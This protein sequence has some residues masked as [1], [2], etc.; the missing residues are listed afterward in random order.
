VDGLYNNNISVAFFGE[1]SGDAEPFGATSKPADRPLT[2]ASTTWSLAP[3]DP[4]WMGETHY[5][6]DLSAVLQEI[7][8]REDWRSGNALAIIAQNADP[9]ATPGVHRRVFAYERFGDGQGVAKLVVTY[10]EPPL[11]ADF[12]GHTLAG[13]IPLTVDFTDRSTGTVTGWLWDFGD[14]ISSTLQNPSHTYSETGSFTVTITVSDNGNQ[15]VKARSDYITTFSP[16]PLQG[17]KGAYFDYSGDPGQPPSDPFLDGAFR[18]ERTD[19]G[20]DFDW[21]SSSPDPDK[22]GDDQFAVRWEGSVRSPYSGDVTFRVRSDDGSKLQVGDQGSEEWIQ[23][24]DCNNAL[25]VAMVAGEW[26]PL[27][28]E[29]FELGDLAHVQLDW[30]LPGESNYAPVPAAYLQV[31]AAVPGL[32]GRYYDYQWAPDEPPPAPF[33]EGVYEFQRVDPTID[34]DWA[35]GS[36]DEHRLGDER[37]AI[38]W[39]GWIRSPVSGMVSFEVHSDD[40]TIL[41]IGGER[42]EM[43]A[44]CDGCD[45]YLDVSMLRGAWYPIRLDFF[46]HT[47]TAHVQLRWKLPGDV[48]F[49]TV[50]E[51]HLLGRRLG[52]REVVYGL[53]SGW[54]LVAPRLGTDPPTAADRALEVIAAQNGDASNIYDWESKRDVWRGHVR[55]LPF[56]NFALELG[57][58]YFLRAEVPSTWECSGQPPESPVPVELHPIWTLIGLPKMP[59]PMAASDLLGEANAQGGACTQV[60]RW[61]SAVSDWQIHIAALPGSDYPLADDEGYFVEC[62]NIITYTPGEGASQAKAEDWPIPVEPA[63]LAPVTD[64]VISDVQVTNRRD[65]ALSVTWRSDGPSIGWVEYAMCQDCQSYRVD[66]DLGEGTVSQVHHVTLTGL[67]P[68]TTYYFR[69]HSGKI[70]D[71]N[72]RALYKVTTKKTGMPPVPY[73]AYGQVETADGQ[74][75]EGALLRVWLVDAENGTSEPLSTMVDG[76]G[77]WS[78]NLSVQECEGLQL[79]LLVFSRQGSEVEWTQPTCE[80]EPVPTVKLHGGH[81]IEVYLPTI[82]QGQK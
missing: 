16:S 60:A 2:S 53:D 79:R 40:G 46:E 12:V 51:E 36:P 24:T 33:D 81:P 19:A 17:L 74:P 75:A 59:G 71:D 41:E 18:F 70:L 26:Y 68:E 58:G 44:I 49:S 6:P 5:S 34:F 62:A 9:D 8:D 38:R 10:A 52:P 25:T 55:G 67:S 37:F 14:G 78:L 73:L 13:T 57:R 50:P 65:V 82:V 20:I 54:N 29:Y 23:C 1:A 11:A 31:P 22:L 47:D 64:P 42:S 3:D 61:D 43:W 48:Q 72:D 30:L 35:E 76:Y 4:W 69:V 27:E 63:T 77:Y 7:V 56:N 66:D 32:S 39:E 28:V 80:V 15:D 45:N 21:G